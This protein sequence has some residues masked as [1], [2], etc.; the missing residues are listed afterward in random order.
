MHC[1]GKC[2]DDNGFDFMNYA[3]DIQSRMP[4]SGLLNIEA[5]LS[6]CNHTYNVTKQFKQSRTKIYQNATLN[7]YMDQ[8]E[9]VKTCVYTNACTSVYR[10]KHIK[11]PH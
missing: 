4:E 1:G 9:I 6:H 8:K 10:A 11:V 7:I 2:V 5:I 3:S